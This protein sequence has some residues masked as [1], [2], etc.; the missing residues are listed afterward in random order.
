MLSTIHVN[1]RNV[2][3]I[4]LGTIAYGFIPAS[5]VGLA[6]ILDRNVILTLLVLP[7]I[8]A[9]IHRSPH[10]A[11]AITALSVMF[12]EALHYNLG[13]IPRQVT[14]LSDVFILLFA[15][16]VF[17]FAKAK[18]MDQ[19][20]PFRIPLLLFSVV[21]VCS[22]LLNRVSP[23]VTLVTIRQ[24]F[25]YVILYLA[26]TSLPM[27]L[28][29]IS[30]SLRFLFHV[31]LI[32]V[33]IIIICFLLGIRG[34]YLAGGLGSAGGTAVLVVLCIA[35]ANVFIAEYIHR[36]RFLSLL[37][38]LAVSMVPA[39]SEIK[40][41]ILILPIS[42]T[43][44]AL[45]A[46]AKHSKRALITA[47]ILVPLVLGLI[48]AYRSIYPS[49][50]ARFGSWSYWSDYVNQEYEIEKLPGH[51]YLGRMA[52]IRIASTH[53]T[54]NLAAAFFGEGPGETSDSYFEAGKGSL[55]PTILGDVSG[56]QF[57]LVLLE[58]GILGLFLSGWIMIRLPR[59]LAKLYKVTTIG[60]DK[61]LICGLFGTSM[62]LIACI[63]YMPVIFY[64]DPT[65]YLFWVSAAYLSLSMRKL[66]EPSGQLT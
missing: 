45:L 56:I 34:D 20:D 43:I 30:W 64:A 44:T 31:V 18:F 27:S 41:G 7:A 28:K 8:A 46:F 6:L 35:S 59:G 5:I 52:R 32:Q 58:L 13:L 14:W 11:L 4:S 60:E 3:R 63:F 53:I 37:K 12:V 54:D 21:F 16:R 23:I 47:I 15:F 50:F 1:A 2:F 25:K 38:F 51:L 42:V 10:V 17:F 29:D 33:P 9:V 61:A 65:S 48:M 26:I 57:S 24:Y 55:Y 19:R 49:T 39:I 66:K 40:F 62:I 36:R 22:T